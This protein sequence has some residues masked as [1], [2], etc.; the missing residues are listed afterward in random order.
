MFTGLRHITFVF[1]RVRDCQG[2]ELGM[3]LLRHLCGISL[4]GIFCLLEQIV[5]VTTIGILL[6]YTPEQHSGTALGHSCQAGYNSMCDQG[7]PAAGG[8]NRCKPGAVRS[9]CGQKLCLD[10]FS[11]MRELPLRSCAPAVHSA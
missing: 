8:A 6:R 1:S 11:H 2:T 4:F 9:T 10:L 3:M 7:L 5:N